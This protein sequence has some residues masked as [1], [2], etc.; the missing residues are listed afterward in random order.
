VRG[1]LAEGVNGP[2]AGLPLP[3]ASLT[4]PCTNSV[5]VVELCWRFQCSTTSVPVNRPRVRG[6]P[7]RWVRG[8]LQVPETPHIDLFCHL[9]QVRPWSRSPTICCLRRDEQEERRDAGEAGTAKLMAHGSPGNRPARRRSG[10]GSDPGRT[11]R[12]PLN[13]HGVTLTAQPQ[14]GGGGASYSS[15]S[16]RA[17]R[18]RWPSGCDV[19]VDVEEVAGIVRPLDLDQAV[20]VLA[21]VVLDLVVIVILHEVDVAAGL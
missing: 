20:V 19:L 1:R 11:S 14:G 5:A 7:R 18:I 9:I 3:L 10:A 6:G 17:R 16:D 8:R 4:H 13:L 15:A 2:P 12:P 21:V